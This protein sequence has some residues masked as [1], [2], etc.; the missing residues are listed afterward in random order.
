MKCPSCGR[1]L[2]P[3]TAGKCPDCDRPR[4]YGKAFGSVF[5]LEAFI[6]VFLV[7]FLVGLIAIGLWLT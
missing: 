3:N 1:V 7:L 4:Q 2:T 6:W 5:S